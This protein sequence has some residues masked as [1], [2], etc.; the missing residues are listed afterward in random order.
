MQLDV[1]L[2]VEVATALVLLG[3]VAQVVKS[4]KEEMGRVR[5]GMVSLGKSVADLDKQIAVL[6]ALN[7][8]G[9]K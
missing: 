4:L 6:K 7:D 9:E 2:I 5:D 3:G 1:H 8:K